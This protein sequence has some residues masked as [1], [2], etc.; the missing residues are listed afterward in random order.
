KFGH[1]LCKGLRQTMTPMMRPF[2][3]SPRRRCATGPSLSP[4]KGGEGLVSRQEHSW[5]SVTAAAQSGAIP[6]T[7]LRFRG[8]DEYG[9]PQGL[10]AAPNA[11]VT[12]QRPARPPPDG[13]T[14]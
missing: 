4:L 2:T 5:L 6:R 8:D 11:G 3:L 13:H 9:C 14:D 7:A 10:L 1:R 12:K